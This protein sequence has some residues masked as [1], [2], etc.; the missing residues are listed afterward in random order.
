[1]SILGSRNL[2][3]CCCLL[4]CLPLGCVAALNI[5]ATVGSDVTLPCTYD[6]Q[7]YGTLSFC[8]G[9]GDIPNSG[10]ANEVIQSDGTSVISRLSERYLLMGDIHVGDLSL[11]IRQVQEDDSGSYGCR[12]AVPGWFN[13]HKHQMILTVVPTYPKPLRVQIGEVRERA[14]TVYWT[15]AFDGGSP[16]TSFRIDLKNEMAPWD[17]AVTTS[18]I[19]P[20]LTEATLVDL[21]PAQAYNLRVFA[22]NKVGMS[23]ASNVLTIP[24]KEAA[25]DGPPLDMQMEALTPHSIKVSWKPP[26][27]DLRNGVLRSYS[28]SYREYDPV[29]RQFKR[30][31]HQ[32]MMATRE[33][34]SLTLTNLRPSTMYGV[35]VQ[36]RTNA[37]VGPSATEPLCYTLDEAHTTSSTEAIQTTSTAA[38]KRQHSTT[39]STAV[40]TTSTAGTMGTPAATVWGQ[41]TTGFALAPPEPPVVQ[42]WE[43]R[44]YMVELFWYAG[45]DGGSPITGYDMEYKA[46]NASWDSIKMVL[47]FSPSQTTAMIMD[48]FPSTYNI[49]MFARNS[50]GRSD[51]SNVLTVTIGETGHRDTGATASTLPP[52]TQ[53]TEFVKVSAI[54]VPLILLVLIAAIVTT[55][56]LWRVKHNSGTFT[57]WLTN[58]RLRF[59]GSESLQEL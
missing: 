40:H 55:W 2:L 19:K 42:L 47:D 51:A 46:L 50:L 27:P 17:A 3:I 30:W 11:T 24:T 58:V 8:W 41:S 18:D 44:N 36:A 53:T 4:L 28:I 59:R 5:G 31:Q 22:I 35:L 14:I 13:D 39:A 21:H 12:V 57:P 45:F 6:V 49:R 32:D 9:R 20:E 56:Q 29:S 15:P 10:C 48:I 37:G 54:V 34:E 38:T 25:P 52:Y 16:I 43:V 33:Q 1:M 26:R 23:E 7:Y